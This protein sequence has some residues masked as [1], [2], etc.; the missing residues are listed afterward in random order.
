MAGERSSQT[1]RTADLEAALK[2][3]WRE[4]AH[5]VTKETPRGSARDWIMQQTTWLPSEWPPTPGTVWTRYVYGLDVALDGVAGVSAPIARVERKTGEDPNR[6]LI[7]MARRLK[8]VAARPVRPKGGWRYTG[9]D[10]KR[11]LAQVLS[12]TQA[13][14]AEAKDALG[15]VAYYRSWKLGNEEITAEVAARHREFFAWLARRK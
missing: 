1:M 2:T 4:T 8:V 3:L 7:P 10:E 6:I 9:D 5:E 11:V 12:L 13:Q 14:P 15:L